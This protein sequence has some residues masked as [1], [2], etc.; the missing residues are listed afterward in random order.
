MGLAQ[1]F[2]RRVV[3]RPLRAED[4]TPGQPVGVVNPPLAF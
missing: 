4:E 2:Y 1:D 3:G